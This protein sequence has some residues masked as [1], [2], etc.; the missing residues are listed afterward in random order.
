MV[1][2]WRGAAHIIYNLEDN[3]TFEMI[4]FPLKLLRLFPLPPSRCPAFLFHKERPRHL[5]SFRL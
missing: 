4:L 1:H 5:Y 2:T 3:H